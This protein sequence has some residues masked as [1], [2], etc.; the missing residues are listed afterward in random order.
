MLGAL[1]ERGFELV[2]EAEEADVLIVTTCAADEELKEESI[3]LILALAE[4][5]TEGSAERL[6]VTGC[7]SQRFGAV[8]ARELPEIDYLLGSS[9]FELI[10]DA[11]GGSLE[12]RLNLDRAPLLPSAVDPRYPFDAVGSG[13]VMVAAAEEAAAC[14]LIPPAR[15]VQ[16]ARSIDDI[17][18]EAIGYAAS[19]YQE[20][21]IFADDLAAYAE[22]GALTELLRRLD[23][24]S[25]LEWVR[26][27][28]LH[29]RG[30]DAELLGVIDA[31]PH[32][33]PYFELPLLHVSDRVLKM[34][35]Q[36]EPGSELR[37]M[38][39]RLRG[40]D[41]AALSARFVVGYPGETDADFGELYGWV[42][43]GVFD[44]VGVSLWT[45]E[46][47]DPSSKLPG[48]CPPELA[49]E[50]RD[51]LLELQADIS[52]RRNEALIGSRM[53]VLVDGVSGEHEWVF[54][55]RH[56]GQAAPYDGRVFLSFEEDSPEE[57]YD[58]IVEVEIDD[59]SDYDL[60]GRV[61][62]PEGEW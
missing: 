7:L 21:Q 53:L 28:G 58:A 34:M 43:E 41:G 52:R 27:R 22:G 46:E 48:R 49:E 15:L 17:M 62:D 44:H 19:G 24:E 50:R 51:E 3:D 56:Y 9:A 47:D 14:R 38:V 33:L 4:L 10:A 6:I 31:S 26:L 13:L 32:V 20:I 25:G 29:P 35:G 2:E 42:D 30:L 18:E 45:P 23:R 11:A 8:L 5:K 54:E 12:S 59:A 16:R 55:G 40:L 1:D 39:E 57:L 61:V 37:G 60:V 36:P